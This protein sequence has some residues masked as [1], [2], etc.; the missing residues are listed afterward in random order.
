LGV[1]GGKVLSEEGSLLARGGPGRVR[2]EEVVALGVGAGEE[3]A[4]VVVAAGE[5]L[6]GLGWALGGRG[7]EGEG[8]GVGGVVV[9]AEVAVPG[10]GSGMV[11]LGDSIRAGLLRN[12][13][14]T[15]TTPLPHAVCWRLR[16]RRSGPGTGTGIGIGPDGAHAARPGVGAWGSRRSQL[17][18]WVWRGWQL[19]RVTST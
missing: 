4:M 1:G 9:G 19:W 3:A 11:L 15:D 13:L 8:V 14:L 17:I 6:G 12:P 5:G 2:W 18:C 10:V 16:L 7:R